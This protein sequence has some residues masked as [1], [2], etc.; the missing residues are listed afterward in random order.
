[1]VVRSLQAL[2][3]YV[4]HNTILKG[5]YF[6]YYKWSYQNCLAVEIQMISIITI[7]DTY[8]VHLKQINEQRFL[9]VLLGA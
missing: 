9:K 5:K 6:T 3:N 1:M 4:N 7:S 2:L 8:L